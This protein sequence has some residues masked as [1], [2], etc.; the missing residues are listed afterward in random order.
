MSGQQPSGS[1]NQSQGESKIVKNGGKMANSRNHEMMMSPAPASPP[2]REPVLENDI[3]GVGLL[4]P[5]PSSPS[6][7]EWVELLEQVHRLNLL[8]ETK[9]EQ[10]L[11]LSYEFN[12][13]Q[14]AEKAAQN[15]GRGV[16]QEGGRGAAGYLTPPPCFNTDV[17]KYREINAR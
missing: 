10:V 8:L 6:F 12:S 5:P 16:E 13:L 9:E 1:G 14:E 2:R 11:A 4:V 7:Y 17:I 15:G 3:D